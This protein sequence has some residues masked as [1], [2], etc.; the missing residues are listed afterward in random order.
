M[1]ISLLNAVLMLEVLR[2][3][4]SVLSIDMGYI[5]GKVETLS[6][7]DV[8][9]TLTIGGSIRGETAH[10]LA[11]VNWHCTSIFPSTA[12]YP[13]LIREKESLDA[14]ICRTS[15]RL[16]YSSCA[17]SFVNF[18]RVPLIL[19]RKPMEQASEEIGLIILK[20]LG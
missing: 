2:I 15:T 8:E 17:V 14:W 13:T 16:D 9:E 18:V 7:V 4:I 12:F 11:S 20:S 5:S 10:T 3:F 1:E 6:S 19:A